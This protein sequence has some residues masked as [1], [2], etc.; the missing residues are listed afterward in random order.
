M[1][2]YYFTASIDCLTW[3]ADTATW[4]HQ[5]NELIVNYG[6]ITGLLLLQPF[7]GSLDFDQDTRWAS[8]RKV[9]QS[10]FPGARDS[11]W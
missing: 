3:H 11:E 10:G 2:N 7:Y 6:L 8:T 4:L 5:T 9:N 1:W